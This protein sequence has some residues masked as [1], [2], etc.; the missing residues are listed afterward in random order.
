MGEYNNQVGGKGKSEKRI[1][2]EFGLA[3][4]LKEDGN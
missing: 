1:M 3:G 2:G 4:R